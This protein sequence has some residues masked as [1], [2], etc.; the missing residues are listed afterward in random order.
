M[1]TMT[2]K[3]NDT[4]NELRML[5]SFSFT[6]IR[7]MITFACKINYFIGIADNMRHFL[8]LSNTPTTYCRPH[9]MP[10]F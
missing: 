6:L 4:N 10:M 2:I 7:Y 1:K 5:H 8:S 3:A 9:K